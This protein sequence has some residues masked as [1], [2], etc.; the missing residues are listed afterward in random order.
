MIFRVLLLDAQLL[1]RVRLI[2]TGAYNLMVL[3]IDLGLLLLNKLRML[4]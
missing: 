1:L 2:S 4:C 3:R